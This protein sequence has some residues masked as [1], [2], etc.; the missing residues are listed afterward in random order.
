MGE[1]GY[2]GRGGRRKEGEGRKGQRAREGGLSVGE[3][4]V[5]AGD[6]EM[7]RSFFFLRMMRNEAKVIHLMHSVNNSFGFNQTMQDLCNCPSI[8]LCIYFFV[9]PLQCS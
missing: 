3:R 2:V 6:G 7:H 9:H 5:S 8:Y 1:R 4:E